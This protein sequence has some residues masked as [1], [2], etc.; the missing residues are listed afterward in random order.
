MRNVPPTDRARA[1][2]TGARPPATP[3]SRSL[4]DDGQLQLLRTSTGQLPSPS[5]TATTSA[6]RSLIGQQSSSPRGSSRPAHVERQWKSGYFAASTAARHTPRCSEATEGADTPTTIFRHAVRQQGHNERL[7]H[8]HPFLEVTVC[9]A[10]GTPLPGTSANL[11]EMDWQL[12]AAPQSCWRITCACG[13][14]E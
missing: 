11:T 8:G 6:C 13:P 9:P 10:L 14:V 2:P 1:L 12:V 7:A 3:G 4:G 5:P